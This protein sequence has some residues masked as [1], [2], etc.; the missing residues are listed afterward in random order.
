MQEEEL[1]TLLAQWARMEP[2]RCRKLDDLR[3]D[4]EYLGYWIPITALPISHGAIIASVLSGCQA[5]RIHCEIDYT[6]RYEQQPATVEVGC[7]PRAF[8]WDEGEEIISSIPSLLLQE[9]LE[10]LEQR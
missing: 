10:R 5:N 1:P 4:V 9:Y 2:E 7:I 3:F 6:P 8:R